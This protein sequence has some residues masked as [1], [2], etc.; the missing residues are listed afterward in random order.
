MAN[1]KLCDLQQPRPHLHQLHPVLWQVS[2]LNKDSQ[3]VNLHSAFDNISCN[4]PTP[5]NSSTPSTA[6]QF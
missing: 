3:K 6:Q 4:A 1:C 2:Q 5:S